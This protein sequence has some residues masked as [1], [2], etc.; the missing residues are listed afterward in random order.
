MAESSEPRI[1]DPVIERRL[2]VADEPDRAVIVTIGKP[3]PDPD[4]D[5]ACTFRV[6]GIAGSRGTDAHGIDGLQA[7]LN[8]IEGARVALSASGMS[9]SWEGGEP[10]DTGIP[11]T[12]PMFYGRSFAE[13]I[14]RYIDQQVHAFAKAAELI[15]GPSDTRGPADPEAKLAEL[16]RK[17]D[18][19]A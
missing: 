15:R 4:G 10:G 6:D 13:G 7:L 17:P 16:E 18:E 11:R 9:L 1:D 5:W 19:E 14:E 3:H 8:A 12:V 2:S